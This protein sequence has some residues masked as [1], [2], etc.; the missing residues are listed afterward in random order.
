M[1]LD[2]A[3]TVE[4]ACRLIAE[5]GAGGARLAVFP[6]AFIPTYPLW[7]WFI[8]PGDTKSLRELYAELVDQAVTI[9]DGTTDRLCAA[10]KAA[11][12]NVAIGVNERNADASGASLY[13]TV[14]CIGADGRIAGLH[15]KLVPTTAERLVWARGDGSPLDGWDLPLGR[16]AALICWEMYMPLA[17][18]ALWAGGTQILAAPT[19]DNGEPW[20]STLRH[21]AKE[22]R[23]YVLGTCSVVRRDDIPDRYRFKQRYLS[24]AGEWINKGDSAIVDPDGKLLAG[25]VSEREELLYAE[26]DPRNYLGPRFQLDTGGHYA[27][28]DIFELTVSREARPMLRTAKRRKRAAKK[29]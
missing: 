18:Y 3:A 2:R 15:R 25:P 9:P 17:R 11:G 27:R 21:T 6:E 19:W 13:N 16:L 29:R 26:V 14:V 4:K 5:A 22:G 10:A 12:V 24:E 28:P 7:V 23:V 8:P 1:F 20:V